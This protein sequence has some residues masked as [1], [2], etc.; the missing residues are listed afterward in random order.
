MADASLDRS[1][2]ISIIYS[3]ANRKADVAQQL[4]PAR[5]AIVLAETSRAVQKSP[6]DS[7]LDR[8]TAV[9]SW[10]RGGAVVD[11]RGTTRHGDRPKVAKCA[12]VVCAN[13]DRMAWPRDLLWLTC[14]S[15]VH[16]RGCAH[17]ICTRNDG[18]RSN[19]SYARPVN[20]HRTKWYIRYLAS[21]IVTA[22]V[23]SDRGPS[24]GSPSWK[25]ETAAILVNNLAPTRY[26]LV[27]LTYHH[28]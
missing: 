20:G 8:R 9:A 25:R 5:R 23:V 12:R 26:I 1:P 6:R 10:K 24:A 2:A 28:Q 7:Q 14:L 17:R 19:A 3:M 22:R 21:R 15:C 16:L 13:C 18:A 11:E 4:H 27:Y